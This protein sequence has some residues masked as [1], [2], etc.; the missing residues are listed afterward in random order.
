MKNSN[1]FNIS[2]QNID[3]DYLLEPPRRGGSNK[4]PLSMF[5]SSNKKIKVYPCKTKFYC[6]KVGF[7]RVKT[8]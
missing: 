4:Y 6:I 8:M 2:A 5:L 3:C 1:S 7:K